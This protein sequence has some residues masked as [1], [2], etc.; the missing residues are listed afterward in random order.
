LDTKGFAAALG[1]VL[2]SDRLWQDFRLE[3]SVVQGTRYGLA[4]EYEERLTI[5]G[6]GQARLFRRRSPADTEVLPPGSYAGAIA[7]EELQA[8]LRL[9]QNAPLHA[10]PAL[11]PSPHDAVFTLTV[12]ANR[13]LFAFRW[14]PPQPPVP[15]DLEPVLDTLSLWSRRVCS[16]PLWS[17]SL[18]AQS[19]HITGEG[20]EALLR[21]ENAGEEPIFLVHPASPGSPDRQGLSVRHGVYPKEVPGVTPLPMQVSADELAVPA[22]SEIE[23]VPVAAGRPFD[24]TLRAAAPFGEGGGRVGIF[25]Y[26]SYAFPA[27]AVGLPVFMGALFSPETRL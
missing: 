6:D 27:G 2:A 20:L 13:K 16:K 15:P 25:E 12:L 1:H 8:F 17:L 22:L 14:S 24:Y 26:K 18:K 7:K 4:Y 9:A 21:F 11:V 19:V 23:L 5:G 3:Y 10:V